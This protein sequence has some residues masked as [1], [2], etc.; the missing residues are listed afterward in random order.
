MGALALPA[1][2]S[3]LPGFF[4]S[5]TQQIWGGLGSLTAGSGRSCCGNVC[6]GPA[7]MLLTAC[8]LPLTAPGCAAWLLLVVFGDRKA[9]WRPP[10]WVLSVLTQ[11]LCSN[12]R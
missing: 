3:L 5:L 6:A 11:T 1:A 7:R 10:E 8:V 9:K 12:K 4:H 2:S